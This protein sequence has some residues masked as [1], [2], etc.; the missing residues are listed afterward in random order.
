RAVTSRSTSKVLA[1]TRGKWGKRGACPQFGGTSN[2]RRAGDYFSISL[3]PHRVT[4]A[5]AT[6]TIV[7]ISV[8][9]GQAICTPP[10]N[11]PFGHISGLI[12]IINTSEQI[13]PAA[14][15]R[16]LPRFQNI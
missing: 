10:P 7:P 3:V 15:D 5:T 12:A 6:V 11:N 9:H 16:A 1:K 14:T 13:I 8:N 2:E 4:H